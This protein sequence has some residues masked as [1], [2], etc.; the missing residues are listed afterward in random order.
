MKNIKIIYF[1]LLFFSFI[2]FEG[3]KTSESNLYTNMPSSEEV[4]RSTTKRAEVLVEKSGAQL[5]GENC[6]R[7]H[8]APPPQA[9]SNEQWDVIG[10][11]M[12]VRANISKDKTE[13]IIAFIKSAN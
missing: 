2:V 13:K 5:W 1:M 6:V 10:Q 8:N 4:N 9:Y 12:R 7:C 3:C 11:H